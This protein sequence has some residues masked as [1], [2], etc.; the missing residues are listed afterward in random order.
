M[1][2][3]TFSKKSTT[4][5]EKTVYQFDYD[6]VLTWGVKVTDVKVTLVLPFLALDVRPVR[7]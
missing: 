2:A 6:L 7:F 5:V 4:I 3:N 1:A